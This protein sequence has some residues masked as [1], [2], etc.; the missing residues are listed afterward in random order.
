MHLLHE[1][2]GLF[3]GHEVA[4]VVNYGLPG[5]VGGESVYEASLYVAK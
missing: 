5:D 1:G 4:C 3:L 2:L